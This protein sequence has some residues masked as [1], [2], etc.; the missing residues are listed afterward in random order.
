MLVVE[1]K[2]NL[3]VREL[4]GKGYSLGVLIKNNFDVPKGFVIISEAF[5]KF[6]K[7]NNLTERIEKLAS[8]ID[9]DN[10]QER[11]EKI[12]NLILNGKMAEEI[13]S[14][15]NE[16]LSKLNLQSVSIRSSAVS[17]DSLKASFA[18]LY[19]T[20]LNIKSEPD[21]VSNY[22]KKCW[23]SLF[24]GRAVAYRIRKGF[25]HLEGMAVV[26]QEMIPAKV[27]G[28]TFTVHPLDKKNLVIES[29]YGIGD[30][31][32]SGKI[33]PDY[34]IID[35]K[36]LEIKEKK[37]KRKDKMSTAKEG[38]IK[39]VEVEKRLAEKQVLS[40]DKLK[41][42]AKTCLKVENL[43]NYPQDIEWCIADSRL[44]LLQS[45]AITDVTK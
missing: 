12:K 19:D 6:L 1:L 4:G 41:E 23:A 38:E 31:I 20:F 35:R 8:D 45:R 26:I 5:F 15:I 28:I 33:D 7:Y 36:S 13:V 39:V 10:F 17:E 9:K 29:S 40:E 27:S 42:I 30:M 16:S 44:W 21:I 34:Y 43:F 11:S 32:V 22:I 37:I 25:P 24:N 3:S 18:G 14:E 2:N